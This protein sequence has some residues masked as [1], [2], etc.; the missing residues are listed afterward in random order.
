MSHSHL[1]ITTPEQYKAMGN[2]LRQRILFQLGEPATLSQ[3]AAR[4]GTGKGTIAHHLKVLKDAGLVTPGESRRVR[5][6]TE[7]YYRRAAARIDLTPSATDATAA[8]L[9]GVATELSRATEEPLLVLRHVRLSPENARRLREELHRIT[10]ELSSDDGEPQ[11]HG[12]LV[13]M[14]Q[15]NHDATG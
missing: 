13:A 4:L 11:R 5:G 8:L 15:E 3:L 7:Q 12:V 9:G 2:P 10:E 14:Y 6:G 1:E